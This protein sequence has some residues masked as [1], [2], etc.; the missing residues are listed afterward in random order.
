MMLFIVLRKIRS[1]YFAGGSDAGIR[2]AI[3]QPARTQYDVILHHR[4]MIICCIKD[5]F[6][7][8]LRVNIVISSKDIFTLSEQYSIILL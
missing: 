2:D 3:V 8:P 7:C 5:C 4:F 1:S 6:A